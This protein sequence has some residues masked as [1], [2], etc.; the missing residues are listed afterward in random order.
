MS[1]REF[2]KIVREAKKANQKKKKKKK[3]RTNATTDCLCLILNVP[4]KIGT[5]ACTPPHLP[6][7]GGFRA[8]QQH[9]AWSLRF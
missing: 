3:I 2:R 1:V 5:V 6:A 4:N 8:R 9:Q 7:F